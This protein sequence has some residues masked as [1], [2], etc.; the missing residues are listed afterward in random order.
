MKTAALFL[1]SLFASFASVQAG[2][3]LTCYDACN[4]SCFANASGDVRRY[5]NDHTKVFMDRKWAEIQRKCTRRN[6]NGLRGNVEEEEQEVQEERELAMTQ[7]QLP[8]MDCYNNVWVCNFYRRRL[9]MSYPDDEEAE[10]HEFDL[11]EGDELHQLELEG[12]E[13]HQLEL[14]GGDELH[15]EL[16]YTKKGQ[17]SKSLKGFWNEK[18]V[19]YTYSEGKCAEKIQCT[20]KWSIYCQ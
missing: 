11:E 5:I 4:K 1:V 16:G 9:D 18:N 19:D 7:R 3:K 15:R 10:L 13:I 12:D 6:L 8:S 20:L 14:E 2:L 17:Y